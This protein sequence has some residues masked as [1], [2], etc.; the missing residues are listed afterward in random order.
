MTRIFFA[1]AVLASIVGC[2]DPRELEE[3]VTAI[4]I[5]TDVDEDNVVDVD[6]G[7]RALSASPRGDSE[8]VSFSL[9]LAVGSHDVDVVV[10]ERDSDGSLEV[11]SC[12]TVVVTVPA[13]ASAASP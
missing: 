7:T 12:G 6:L 1:L 10:S 2:R 3:S 13:D 4:L 9:A 11:E 5:V 8:A